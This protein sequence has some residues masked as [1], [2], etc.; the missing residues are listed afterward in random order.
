MKTRETVSQ[1]IRRSG[2]I[3]TEF[4]SNELNQLSEEMKN[5]TSS[6]LKNLIF[7]KMNIERIQKTREPLYVKYGF[8]SEEEMTNFIRERKK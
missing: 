5:G 2:S 7:E 8:T 1:I 4:N 3:W 6:T